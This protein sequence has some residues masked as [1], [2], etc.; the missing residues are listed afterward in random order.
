MRSARERCRGFLRGM[1]NRVQQK[2]GRN[3]QPVQSIVHSG[4]YKADFADEFLLGELFERD[5]RSPV[6]V[7]VRLNEAAM[8]KSVHVD[9]TWT[10][11]QRFDQPYKRERKS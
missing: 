1:I 8:P 7:L 3:A 5:K 11:A 9:G 6:V 10:S 2:T 4:L